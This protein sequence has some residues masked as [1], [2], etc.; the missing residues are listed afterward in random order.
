M[1][2][3]ETWLM[4]ETYPSYMDALVPM[5]AEPAA[6]SGRNWMMRQMLIDA[7]EAD[8]S[9]DGGDYKD[10]PKALHIDTVMFSIATSGGTMAYQANAPS[11][12]M[13][14]AII[15]KDIE[16]PFH[17]DADDEIF[18]VASSSDYDP[19]PG[20]MTIT[21]PV[22]TIDFADDERNPM[23]TGLMESGLKHVRHAH[24]LLI[25]A[26]AQTYGGHGTVGYAHFY[27]P[28]LAAFR[29]NAPKRSS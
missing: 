23:E 14:D 26:S 9:W 11:S 3:M 5:A 20:L 28:H 27:A 2:G 18:Q 16:T 4:G 15:I 1:G 10:E 21:A 24:L 22:L 29:D 8:P 6:I 12:G 25:P 17:I 7:V 13:G 19:T